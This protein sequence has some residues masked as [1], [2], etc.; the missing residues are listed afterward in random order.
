VSSS[1]GKMTEKESVKESG[2]REREGV[3]GAR[4]EGAPL[5]L[6]LEVADVF[7]APVPAFAVKLGES[8]GEHERPQPPGVER[9]AFAEVG[10]VEGVDE[11][12]FHLPD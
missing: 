6:V 7:P 2:V 11:T 5:A 4:A 3:G 10:N 9:F 8:V 12:L 1:C